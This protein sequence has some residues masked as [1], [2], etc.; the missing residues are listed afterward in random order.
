MLRCRDQAN[1]HVAIGYQWSFSRA[2]Q[3]L[4]ADILSGALGRPRR[5]KS[6]VLWPR[7]EA[8]YA[9]NRW[10]GAV[11]DAAGAWILDSPVNNACAHYLHN[12]LY[13]AGSQVDRSASLATVTAELYRA[14]PIANYDTAALRCRT[15]DDIEILFIASH[16]TANRRGPNFFCEFERGTVEFSDTPGATILA[17]FADGSTKDYGS[18]GESR[19]HKLWD[20]IDAIHRGENS[21]CGIE[22]AAVHTQCAWFAQQSATGITTFPQSLIHITGTSPARKT[23]VQGLGETLEN[24]YGRWQ[25][26]SEIGA[27]WATA[28]RE[29]PVVQLP[30]T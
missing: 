20:T 22:A 13:L 5:L 25:L 30:E 24:C 10:A 6:L 9:R 2:I 28:A 1:K 4:K 23:S 15:T 21:V 27:A 29:I 16:A 14:H 18:P 3:N 12:L 11:R 8:Y 26:P 7:D 17:R 19:D